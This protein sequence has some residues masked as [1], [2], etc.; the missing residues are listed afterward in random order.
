M[1]LP[2]ESSILSHL[3]DRFSDDWHISSVQTI[4]RI[5]EVHG[6]IL[7]ARLPHVALAELCLIDDHLY[8]EVIGIKKDHVVLSPFSQPLGIHSGSIVRPLHQQHRIQVGEHLLG[9]VVDGFGHI[10]T[11]TQKIP[12]QS[13]FRKTRGNIPNPLTRTIIHQPLLLGIRAID[14]CLTMGIGQRIGIF[15]SAGVG[16]STLL[17]MITKG[18]QADIVVLALVG[19]RGREVREF[20][21]QTL[22]EAARKRVVAIVATSDR[23]ALE[24]RRA[25][26]V[27]TT[28]AEYFRDQGKNVLLLMDSV[29][30]FARAMRELGLAAGEPM[31]PSGFPTSVFA[32]LPQLLERAGPAK[33][34]SITA[35]YTVLAEKENAQDPLAEEVRSILDGHI[36]LSRKL[37]EQGHYPAIDIL[38]SIS[39]LMTQVTS[40]KH[41]QYVMKLRRLLAQYLEVELLLRVGEYQRGEDLL[42]DEAVARHEKINL[43]LRQEATNHDSL[44]AL[45]EQLEQ[46]LEAPC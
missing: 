9:A 29:T 26:E 6:M 22:D 8:A 14:S 28:I 38:R 23:S 11:A 18:T 3:K 31:P 7:H 33:T 44:E 27:A 46:I 36:I 17:S 34:G 20:L 2:D 5:T 1:R 35:I 37:A 15:S 43:F 32:A 12:P 24:R 41:Q 16:K 10:L 19:E 39:R 45:L 40:T 25:P 21:E 13:A 30:R 4:G 42:A